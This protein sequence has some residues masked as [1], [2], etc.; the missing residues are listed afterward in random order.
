[1]TTLP[2]TPAPLVEARGARIPAIGLGTWPMKGAECVR[3]VA[4]ALETG[5]RHIDTASMYGNEA[6]VGEGLRSSG[7]GRGDVWLTT[8]VWWTDIAEADLQR[9]AEASL[10][11][12]GV[13]FV[14]LLLIHWPNP[15]VPV[16][17]SIAAL[18]DAKQRGLAR[19]I[20]IS[21]FPTALMDQA[22]TAT[23]EPLVCNQ[24]EYHPALDQSK[25]VAKCRAHG[26]AVISYCPLGKGEALESK[27]I[28][29][30]AARHDKTAGQV[31]LRW[32][33]QQPGIIAIPKS[34]NPRRQAENLDVFDF[35]LS[36]AEMGA[37]TA[38]ARHGS[39]RVNPAHHPEWD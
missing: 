11:R 22:F 6:E 26:M 24:F 1:M 29:E 32:H 15:A 28:Q 12:L 39:R 34:A 2:L 4:S 9:S 7:I 16:A 20:G 36:D 14:D 21:N 3:A 8:K 25:L 30:I 33:T 38:L 27:V 35:E 31:V 13:D 17:E 37:I 19:H 23:S 10:R 18:C 5:Y